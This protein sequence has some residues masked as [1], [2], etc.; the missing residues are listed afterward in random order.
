LGRKKCKTK[1]KKEKRCSQCDFQKVKAIEDKTAAMIL[2]GSK[3]RTQDESS[4][5][6]YKMR[7][8]SFDSQLPSLS[9]DRDIRAQKKTLKFGVVNLQCALSCISRG[10]YDS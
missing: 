7:D 8:A 10:C 6:I 3:D 9:L 5:E 1:K 4:D 2:Y